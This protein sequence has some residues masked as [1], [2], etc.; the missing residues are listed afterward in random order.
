VTQQASIMAFA[1][2]YMMLFCVCV[3]MM[4]LV[5]LLGST[6]K[7]AGPQGQAVHALD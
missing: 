2:D 5:F 4:P 6:R 7:A 3:A 1:N